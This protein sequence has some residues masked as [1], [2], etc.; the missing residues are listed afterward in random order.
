VLVCNG[1]TYNFYKIML[2]RIISLIFNSNNIHEVV[3][4]NNNKG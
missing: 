3:D 2:E 1:E 4:N